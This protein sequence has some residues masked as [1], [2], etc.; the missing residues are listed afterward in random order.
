MLNPADEAFANSC[1]GPPFPPHR[2]LQLVVSTDGS[3]PPDIGGAKKFDHTPAT[4]LGATLGGR[5]GS[6]PLTYQACAV[7]PLTVAFT[8]LGAARR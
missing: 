3:T 8:V 1:F 4:R 5:A 6:L 2:V 7:N